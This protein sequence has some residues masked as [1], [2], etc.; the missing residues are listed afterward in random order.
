MVRR[1]DA[2]VVG[3]AWGD[4]AVDGLLGGLVGGV[5]MTLYLVVACAL[6]GE[7]VAAMLQ[8]FAPDG[9]TPLSGLF[10]HL[11]VSGVYGLLF[12]LGWRLVARL[13]LPFVPLVLVY[14]LALWGL[15]VAL[16]LPGSGSTL[17]EIS[18]L[19]LLFAHLVYGLLLSMTLRRMWA[20]P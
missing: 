16:V 20:A 12:A 17:V 9:G 18:P 14:A 4:A 6:E 13:R 5:G 2:P 1:A 19:H 10:M 11:A 8:R 15:A 7:G 3:V